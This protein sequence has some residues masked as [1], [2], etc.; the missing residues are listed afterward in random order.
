MVAGL[1]C[2]RLT[3]LAVGLIRIAV[4]A[5]PALAAFLY[6]GQ[7]AG[8]GAGA[9]GRGGL[10]N[11]CLKARAN[12][13]PEPKPVASAMSSTASAGRQHSRKAPYSSRRR[14]A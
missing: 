6:V 14:R 4:R 8:V 7:A 2:G 9:P 3:G 12:A 11:F 5:W 1:A 13:S 10:P